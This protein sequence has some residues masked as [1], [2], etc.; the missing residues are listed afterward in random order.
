MEYS[1]IYM[2]Y[3]YKHKCII[4]V[5]GNGQYSKGN[6][7]GDIAYVYDIIHGSVNQSLNIIIFNS[8][9]MSVTMTH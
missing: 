8:N 4:L 7:Q 5:Y 6:H 3:R 2:M 1:Y 9:M